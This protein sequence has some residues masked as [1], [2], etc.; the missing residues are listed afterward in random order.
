MKGFYATA[1]KVIL[2]QCGYPVVKSVIKE[3]QLITDRDSL[4]KAI[5]KYF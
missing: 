3:E 2:I 4:D 1:E 5:V